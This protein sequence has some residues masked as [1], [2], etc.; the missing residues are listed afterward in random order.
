MAKPYSVVARTSVI[1]LALGVVGLFVAWREGRLPSASAHHS[2]EELEAFR[3]GGST[4]LAFGQNTYFMASG[5]CQ[6][7]HGP[8]ELNNFSMVDEDGNDVNVGDDWRSTM[9]A[10][11]ARDPFWRAKVSHEVSV[12]PGHQVALEDKCTSCHAPMGR[13]DKFYT[14]GGPYT[15]EELVHDTVAL[16]G[17]SCLSCH[18][19]REEGIGT[20]FSGNLHFDTINVL[21][22]PYGNV[23]GSPMTSFVG[24][25]PLFGAHITKAELCAGCHTLITETADLEGNLTGDEFVEQA[26]Y[27]EWVNS[28]YDTD[29]N[30]EGGVTCQGCHVPRIDDAV[31]ISANYLFL[32]GR[33]PFG[34][35]HFAGANTFMLNL[36][37]NN[38]QELGLTATETQFDSTIARTDRML[39]NNTLLMETQVAGRDQDTAY[40]AVKLSN[41]AGHKFPSGYPAR[42][43]F[44]E[45]VVTN[46]TDDTLFRSGGWDPTYEVIGH[47]ESWE[48]HHDVIRSEDQAQI[49]EM[50]M[51]DVNGDKTTVLERAK[52]SLKDNRLTPVGFST[53]HP[54]YDTTLVANVPDTDID[55]NRDEMGIEG[56]GSDVVRYHVPMSG[57]LGLIRIRAKVWYQSAPPRYMQEMFTFNTEDIDAFRTMYEAADGSPTLVK[58]QEITD[59][60]VQVDDLSE[61]GLRIFPNPVHDGQLRMEGIDPR[62][63]SIEVYT[64]NGQRVGGLVPSGQHR[65]QLKL[66][67]TA[68]T[69]VVVVRTADKQF[70]ERVVAY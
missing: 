65:W 44:V 54:S 35:H 53:S 22:G 52:F 11:S 23:F 13:F 25:E 60:S 66:P 7:C 21:Y 4:A 46:A 50:V 14:G 57:Y 6:G 41:L 59:L 29:A 42:R 12:N 48:P 10:N 64:L 27:H 3:G 43:A 20:E 5:N 36:L 47:D 15:M 38:I 45:V 55:F 16:D 9:M 32:Q 51:G 1:A 30:P 40:I 8:D 17:V 2:A 24:Y 39:Q 19:Q 63:T 34:L 68:A 70:V 67:S 62:I 26:T 18:M 33:S 56:S 37:K 58:E 31:V 61:L 28:I 69:Y 49:Y